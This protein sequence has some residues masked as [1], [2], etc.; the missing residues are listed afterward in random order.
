VVGFS[1]TTGDVSQ[2]ATL[3]NG[4]AKTDLGAAGGL[5]SVANAI[6]DAGNV[7]GYSLNTNG[8]EHA[9]LWSG[10][11]ST[12]LGTLGGTESGAFAIN[13]TGQVVGYASTG[14]GAFHATLWTGTTA[15]DLNSFLDASSVSAGWVVIRA[16]GVNDNGW[17]VGDA[18]NTITGETHGFLLSTVASVPEPET[19]AMMLAG[20]GLVGFMARG[21]KRNKA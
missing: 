12:I 13:N 11:T 6:N 3:W 8:N 17:I 9:I 7:V 4:T 19:Y 5:Y 14:N 2:H 20:L 16:Y 1:Q 18:N 10:T 15:T 21:R